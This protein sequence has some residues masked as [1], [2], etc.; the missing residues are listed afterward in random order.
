MTVYCTSMDE[1]VYPRWR[2]NSTRQRPVV[3]LSLF[4]YAEARHDDQGRKVLS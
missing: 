3:L 1:F 2:N 4:S